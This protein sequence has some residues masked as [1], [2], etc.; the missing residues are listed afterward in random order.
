MNVAVSSCPGY[1]VSLCSFLT[2]GPD[3]AFILSSMMIP[4]GQSAEN[5]CPRNVKTY[6]R[7][8]KL[9]LPDSPSGRFFSLN[10]LTLVPMKSLI[11]DDAGMTGE[12]GNGWV[13]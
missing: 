13:R 9:N 5:R 7:L 8:T 1:V 12:G 2:S 6:F 4:E 11:D 3:D 10:H